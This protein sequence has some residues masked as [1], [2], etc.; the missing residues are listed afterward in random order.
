MKLM[1][2]IIESIAQEAAAAAV[3]EIRI[4]TFWTAVET[5]YGGLASTFFKHKPGMEVPFP[6]AGNLREK[7]VLELC[8]LAHSDNLLRSSLGMAAVNS[9]LEVDLSQYE[10]INA[11]DVLIEKANNK[12]VSLVGH[13]PF[14]KKLKKEAKNL[15]ILEKRPQPGDLSA[16][17]AP[18]VLPKSDLIAI[19]STTLIN[20]TLEGLLKLCP[21][22]AEVMLLG[23]TTPLSPLLFDHQID[24]ISGTRVIEPQKV[25]QMVSEGIVFRQMHGRGIKLLTRFKK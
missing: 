10:E 2:E 15:W 3:K 25:L 4:G 5:K 20:N 16:D 18:E 6:D 22:S 17:K 11:G 13:F 24:I 8:N 19:T 14:V 12:N 21:P 7:N 1:T 23:P 9:M